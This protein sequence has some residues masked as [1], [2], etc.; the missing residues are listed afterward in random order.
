MPSR[1][2]P[3]SQCTPPRS[4][5]GATPSAVATDTSRRPSSRSQQPS[6]SRSSRT[7]ASQVEHLRSTLAMLEDREESRREELDRYPVDVGDND[8]DVTSTR[9][10]FAAKDVFFMLLVVMK[11]GDT[12]DML[13]RIF[14][15][16]TPTFIKTITGFIE[17][18]AP[19][20]QEAWVASQLDDSSMR[21]LVTSG[22]TFQNFPCALYA[23]NVTFQQSNRP[24]GSM[25]ET[26]PFY[27]AKHKSYRF[28]VDVSVNPRGLAVNC[29]RHSRGNTADITMFRN[30]E[31]FHQSARRKADGD[32]RLADNGP[33][34]T[35]Y[36]EE[37]AVLADKGYQGLGD[38]VRGIHPKKGNQLTPEDRRQN[39]LIS[40]D[41]VIVENFL[42]GCA[43][44]GAFVRRNSAGVNRFM[45][46]S[47]KYA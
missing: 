2:S 28:K 5:P 4:L 6:R 13:A 36:P 18:V 43:V 46:T 42:G 3:S 25:A 12:W 27:S 23:T 34:A 40:S 39:E 44:Y 14:R 30:N 1:Q 32:C 24:S 10:T 33:L 15:V 22:H 35:D 11:C 8:T 38:N 45:T 19:K 17:V 16:K 26:M 20:L 7:R 41:R 31:A 47:S 29:T 37:W 9:S 21:V